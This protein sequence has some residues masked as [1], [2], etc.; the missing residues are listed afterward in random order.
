VI[1]NTT[2]FWISSKVSQR[3]EVDDAR[4]Y[5]SNKGKKVISIRSVSVRHNLVRRQFDAL[6]KQY[7]NMTDFKF[8]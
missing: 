2:R 5:F 3:K 8:E 7:E 1:D 6:R 4:E